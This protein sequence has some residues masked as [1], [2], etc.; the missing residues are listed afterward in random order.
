MMPLDPAL[1]AT[2]LSI[3]AR[4]FP[5]G[6]EVSPDAPGT[7]KALKAHLDT[8]KRLVVYDGGCEG[9]I[10]ANPKV[11]HAL[12]AWHD[13]SHWKGEHDFSVEGECAVFVMQR[14]HLLYLY[15]DTEQTRRWINI[16]NAEVVGQR[17]F[18]ERHKRFVEDQRGFIEAYMKSPDDTLLCPLW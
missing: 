5:D 13:Y 6:F 9:T 16:L 8:G 4:L 11:N 7:Y 1:N 12:R 14:R 3:A 18:Y 17:L 10:Y 2:I 15:G